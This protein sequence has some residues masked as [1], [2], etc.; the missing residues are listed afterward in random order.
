[1]KIWGKVFGF[2]FGLMLSKNV[3]GALL[4]MWLGHSFDKGRSLNFNHL[5]GGRGNDQERQTVFFYSSFSVMGYIA[6]ANGQVT[7]HEIAFANAYMDKL[8]LTGE[9]RQQ[10][11]DAFR[12]GKSTEFD[13]EAQLQKFIE[14]CGSRQDLLLLFLEIQIQVA[15]ADGELDQDERRALHQVAKSLGYS[16]KELDKLLEMI[17]AGAQFHQGQNS[18]S[19]V[20]AQQQ[21]DNAYKLLGVNKDTSA[22][23][24]KKSYRKLMSQHHPDKLVAKGLPAEMMEVAK[25]KTQDIQAAYELISETHK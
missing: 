13:L 21:L 15:F 1:M 19:G 3:F 22:K 24:I 7:S 6:K 18:H 17:I 25:Q 16:A 5:A 12:Q 14:F 2:I 8:G 4:G 10:A 11:Q 9:L 23:D 20:S